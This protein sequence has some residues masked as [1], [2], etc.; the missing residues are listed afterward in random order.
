MAPLDPK[1]VCDIIGAI[2]NTKN[3]RVHVDYADAAL[4]MPPQLAKALVPKMKQWIG[5]A[6]GFV[7]VKPPAEKWRQA[8]VLGLAVLVAAAVAGLA[9]W[10]LKPSPSES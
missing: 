10:N 9:V 3:F 2:P 4:A 6:Q 8:V 7:L 1:T 5:E